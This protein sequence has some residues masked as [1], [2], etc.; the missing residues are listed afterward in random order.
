[1]FDLDS[2]DNLEEA[3]KD[4]IELVKRLNAKNIPDDAI[5]LYWSGNKGFTVIVDVDKELSPNELRHVCTKGFGSGLKTLD[6]T[7]YNASR[8][9]RVP[10]TRHNVSGLY[11]IPISKEDLNT[12]TIEAIKKASQ[13][14]N[15]VDDF[16]YG[17]ASVPNDLLNVEEKETIASLKSG[18]LDYSQKPKFLTNCRWA[19]QNGLFKEGQRSHPLLCLAATYKNLGFDIEHT[20]RLLKGVATIQAQR[21]SCKRYPDEEIYNNIVT[22]VYSDSWKNGQY[23]CKQDGWLKDYCES[24]GEHSCSH[25]KKINEPHTLVEIKDSFKDYVKNIDK[26]TVLT[27]IP[28]IDKN[29]FIS[30]GCNVGIIGAPGSGK[31]SIALNILN[32]TSKAGVK[33]VFASL[34]MH[35]NRMFEKVMYKISGLKREELYKAFQDDREG[36]LLEKLKE[37]FGN[38]YFFNKSSPSVNDIKEYV[39]ECQEQSGEKIKMVMLDYFERVSSDFNDDTQASKRVAGELQDMVNDLDVALVT[40]V[41]PHKNA[42]S[43]GPDSPIYD[44][45]KIKG[46]SFVYQSMRVIMSLWRPFYN[47]KDFKNDRIMQMA[48][49]KNDLGELNEFALS[50]DG[51]RGEVQELEDS[52]AWEL[53]EMLNQKASKKESDD[54]E[55]K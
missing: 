2:K 5:Q 31:S 11:K 54:K 43:G 9:L 33:T 15:A 30:T 53:E 41:Q 10:F 40:L 18:D 13:D 17:V 55:W 21:N 49:L 51:K 34:D 19:M 8:I 44:Y 46:S 22:Q 24:L 32:N 38:V 23:S 29:V 16:E 48:V 37:E 3:R 12:S 7:V 26:N 35:R 39:L 20:Y 14:L 6:T 52:Q 42:L 1:V 36:P 50:W 27:G 4:T 45:T 47:P 25:E 28:S